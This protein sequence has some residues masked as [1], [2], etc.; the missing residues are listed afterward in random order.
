MAG[1]AP[2][3]ALLKRHRAASGL[4]QEELAERAG[5]SARTISDTERGLRTS[6]YRDTAERLATALGLDGDERSDFEAVARG[7]SEPRSGSRIPAQPTRLIGRDREL[8]V[9]LEA[10]RDPDTRLVTLTGPG[11]IGKTRL[12]AEAAASAEPDFPDGAYFVPLS[13]L[14]DPKLFASVLA[15]ELDA[16]AVDTLPFDAIVRRLGSI[17]AL[18]VLD[19]FEHVM[20]AAPVVAEL[21]ARCPAITIMVTSREALHIR[22]ESEIPV[23]A[24]ELPSASDDPLASPATA[25][26]VERALATKPDLVVSG[27]AAGIV[28]DICKRLDGVPLALELAAARV[29]HLSL[30]SLRD[31]LEHRLHLLT[32]GPRDLPLRQRTMRDTVAWSYELLDESERPAFRAL[33]VFAGGWTIDAAGAVV[34]GADVLGLLS[35]LVDKNLVFVSQT[36]R[37]GMLDVI[38]E[39]AL[40]QREEAGDSLQ[41]SHAQH[42]L[43]LAEQAEPEF[44][45]SA[46]EEWFERIEEEHDNLRAA[47]RFG[48]DGKDGSLALRIGGALWQFWRAHEHFDEGRAWLREALRL[49]STDGERAK[50][51]WGAAWLAFH[52]ADYDEAGTLSVEALAMA[53]RTGDPIDTRNALAVRG[54]VAMAQAR[55]AEA[56]KSFEEGLELCRSAEPGWLLATSLLNLATA[57]MHAGDLD[58]AEEVFGEAL[59]LYTKLGD[60]RFCNRARMHLAQV[61]LLR[62]DR[63]VAREL[64]STALEDIS[65]IADMNG[66]TELLETLSAIEAV[67]QPRRAALIA[68]VADALRA[69]VHGRPMPFDQAFTE[70]QLDLARE[71]LGEDEWQS[72]WEEGRAM[73]LELA[74]ERAL[75]RGRR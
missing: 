28:R 21:L 4:T 5:V 32:G 3:A 15:H 45:G 33:S 67:V 24:L 2:I 9:I 38:R 54:M 8:G 60:R 39:F 55:Y 47:L 37:Y 31:H 1:D 56:L 69:T 10:L 46:Q 27:D 61:A 72:A 36:G 42:Y 30:P 14:V 18:L 11:G 29:K 6:V 48:L 65:G 64:A 43:A 63:R 59:E 57:T 66:A 74:I 13:S 34:P 26:F 58:R 35:A 49:S 62:G 41:V 23:R 70:R 16:S 19:T 75:E 7:R 53:R 71:A 50:A 52:Q 51:L 73:P 68:G 40:E 12:G 25:L 22:G 20:D 17:R 44:G